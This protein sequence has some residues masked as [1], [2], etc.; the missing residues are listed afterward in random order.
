MK[1]G[2]TMTMKQRDNQEGDLP[3]ELAKPAQRA[4]A[5]AGYWRLDQ[6]TEISEAKLKQLH[7]VGPK[8]IDQLRRAL[9]AK[10][11]AFTDGK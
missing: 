3:T 11:L 6:L 8:A 5:A 4:L 2:I 1:V 7:G 10:G 9:S